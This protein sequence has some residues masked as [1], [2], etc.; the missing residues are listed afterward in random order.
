M[1][2]QRRRKALRPAPGCA[3]KRRAVL[4]DAIV[5]LDRGAMIL[6]HARPARY[7]PGVEESFGTRGYEGR[8]PPTPD[9]VGELARAGAGLESMQQTISFSDQIQ[10]EDIALCEQ[11][12]R[13]LRSRSF[14]RGRF[15]PRREN[16][17]FHFQ[18][19]VREFLAE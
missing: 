7:P 11:V 12:Q 8:D 14:D 15:S 5:R 17:V 9:L 18:S 6:L 2:G 3:T 13:G 1:R 10:Q 16:G 4:T 19:L